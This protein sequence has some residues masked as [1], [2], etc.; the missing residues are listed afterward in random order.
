MS[1]TSNDVPSRHDSLTDIEGYAAILERRGLENSFSIL[2]AF[3]FPGAVVLDVGCG[4]GTVTTDVARLVQPGT[5]TG[6]DLLPAL[7]ER[8][9]NYA[10]TAQTENATF[11]VGNTH[12]L[13]FADKTFDITYSLNVLVHLAD[14]VGA[15]REQARVTKT[16]GIVLANI[17]DYGA[18]IFYPSC[19]AL[20]RLISATA[21]LADPSDPT[22]FMNLFLGRQAL[23]LFAEAGFEVVRVLPE[24]APLMVAHQGSANFEEEHEFLARWTDPQD[25]LLGD[26]VTKLLRL[27]LVDENLLAD[28]KV[29]LTVW[30]GH[31]YALMLDQVAFWGIGKVD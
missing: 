30:Y 2:R 14:P 31:P 18:K 22:N 20:E 3:L 5:V 7:V 11:Q 9:R 6:V 17:G 12:A 16:G 26:A 29:E 25:T 28:A 8:A 1:N 19:P 13:D 27:G 24:A 10:A 15:L 21:Q 23:A 4:P